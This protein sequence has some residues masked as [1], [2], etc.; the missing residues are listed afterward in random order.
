[1][2]CRQTIVCL[3]SQNWSDPLWTNKQHIMSRLA[4]DHRVLHVDFR[5]LPAL[6]LVPAKLR[7]AP[8]SALH[9]VSLLADPHVEEHDGVS[10]L[11]FYAPAATYLFP[12]GHPLRTF[13]SF[14]LHVRLL[15]R[16]LERQNLHDA[17][18][19]VYHPGFGG[20]VARLPHKLLVY[21]CVDEYTA[22]P[23]YRN[24]KDWIASR[25]ESLCR[26][27]DL[28]F[29]TAPG[30]YDRKRA[31]NPD[32]THLVH[33]VG[34]AEHFRRALDASSVVPADIAS[35]PRPVIGFVGA[36]SDYKLNTEWVLA[37][38]QA[39]PGW[40]IVIIGPVGLAD[41]DTDVSRLQQ[42]PNVHLLGTRPYADLPAYLKGFDVAV[43]PYRIND[44]TR[45]V[46]PIKF[47]EFMATGKPVVI[48]NLPALEEFYDAA[49]VARDADELVQR[50]EQALA[51]PDSGRERR[52]ALADEHSW[53]ARVRRLT[54][55]IDTKL[56]ERA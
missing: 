20:G 30:L 56:A 6:R 50:C 5:P 44:Y 4:A 13:A 17:I 28:V 7:A 1:M 22:F 38:A 55:L 33:N 14:D 36:V 46:F 51:D 52:M 42:T 54:Q 40:S 47:F 49:L 25:E 8:G 16:Y 23:D 32:G 3:S 37:L 45:T 48:S 27:A 15:A 2:T 53:P 43:I 11:Q 29:T 18:L 24:C 10:V 19:W 39:R 35:L 26:A 31:F 9:P 12:F 34:D 21:D 41:P